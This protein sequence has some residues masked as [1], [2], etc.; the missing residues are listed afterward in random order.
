MV[1]ALN[2]LN[3]KFY[4]YKH[5]FEFQKVYATIIKEKYIQYYIYKMLDFFPEFFASVLFI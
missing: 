1:G 2:T 5:K 3:L 4:L